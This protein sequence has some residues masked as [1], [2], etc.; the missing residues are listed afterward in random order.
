MRLHAIAAAAAAVVVLATPAA[1]AHA[2]TQDARALLRK[3]DCYTCHADSDAKAAP[4]FAEIAAKYRGDARAAARITAVV[5]NG[6]HG[7]G[8]WPMPPMPQVPDADARRIVEYIL[9][10]RS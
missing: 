7:G 8:P 6:R 2:A 1:S 10:L 9:A 4:P 5:K 3:Y